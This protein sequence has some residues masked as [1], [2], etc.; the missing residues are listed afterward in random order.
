MSRTAATG[1]DSRLLFPYDH[2]RQAHPF[3]VYP[4]D[5]NET[6][7]QLLE[8][9]EPWRQLPSFVFAHQQVAEIRWDTVVKIAGF[10]TGASAQGICA[11]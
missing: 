1:I 9:L 6:I 7:G 4:G 8:D 11:Y 3:R 10:R 2:G 5:C